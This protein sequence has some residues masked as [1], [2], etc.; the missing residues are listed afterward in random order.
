MKRLTTLA[1]IAET[2]LLSVGAWAQDPVVVRGT[3]VSVDQAERI[4]VL[5]D[6][7]MIRVIDTSQI[8]VNA[9]PA[10]LMALEPGTVVAIRGAQPVAVVP[11]TSTALVREPAAARAIIALGATQLWCDGA[12]DRARGTNFGAC[13]RA[14]AG[15]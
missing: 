8:V 14:R 3:V 9:K 11:D 6:G 12:W 1:L 15:D 10:T 13:A 4:V 5:Q 7:R 2:L